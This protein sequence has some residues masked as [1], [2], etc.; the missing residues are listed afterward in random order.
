MS[1]SERR[2]REMLASMGR[3]QS[4]AAIEDFSEVDEG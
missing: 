2:F 4:V 3:P 1:E